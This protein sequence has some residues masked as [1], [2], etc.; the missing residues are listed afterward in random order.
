VFLDCVIAAPVVAWLSH[1]WGAV[2]DTAARPITAAALLAGDERGW[3]VATALRP[4]WTRLRLTTL[5]HLWCASRHARPVGAPPPSAAYVV[6]CIVHDCR[7]AMLRDWARVCD[8]V[9]C[10]AGIPADWLRG[11]SLVLSLA[12]FQA[13]WCHRDMLCRAAAGAARPHL[14]WT[15]SHPVPLALPAEGVG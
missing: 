4:L 9:A 14:R 15:A 7:G 10:G 5:W 8:D 3:P 1:L 6:C 13:R 2:T 11:R 12:D